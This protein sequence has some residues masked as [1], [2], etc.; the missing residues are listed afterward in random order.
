MT[1]RGARFV[2]ARFAIS[3]THVHNAVKET[4]QDVTTPKDLVT[5]FHRDGGMSSCAAELVAV[6]RQDRNL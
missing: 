6:I 2:D 3:M 5:A 1:A 4:F